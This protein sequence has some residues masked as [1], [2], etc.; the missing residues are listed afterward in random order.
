[1]ACCRGLLQV[2]AVEDMSWGMHEFTLTDPSG[3]TI[4]IGR[5]TSEVAS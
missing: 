1:M 5:S 3:N 2:S 4:R